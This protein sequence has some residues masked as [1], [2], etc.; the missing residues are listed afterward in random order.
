MLQR[1]DW[2][3]ARDRHRRGRRSLSLGEVVS[4]EPT[5]SSPFGAAIITLRA[6]VVA[7]L[8]LS[9]NTIHTVWLFIEQRSNNNPQ[10]RC[11]RS[12]KQRVELAMPAYATTP[13]ANWSDSCPLAQCGRSANAS[14][15]PRDHQ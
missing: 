13:P 11:S 2:T 7:L 4:R 15:T 5:S 9:S 8:L 3:A 10:Q 14:S 12:G 6:I 1:E